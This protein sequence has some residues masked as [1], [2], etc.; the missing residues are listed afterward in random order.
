MRIFV[1]LSLTL[2]LL[3]PGALAQ[4]TPA[5]AVLRALAAHGTRWTSGQIADWVSEGKLTYF[6]VDGPQATFSVTLVR[7]GKSRVQ[8]VI[9]QTS[10]ELRQGSDGTTSWDSLGGE[11]APLAQ[12]NTQS[13][14]EAQTVRSIQRLFNYPLEGLSLRDLGATDA[15]RVIE[16]EDTSG[17][18]TS[19][20]ID[21]RTSLITRLEFVIGQSKDLFSQRP[22]PRVE[23][24]V[25][26]DFRVVQEV[27]TPFRI[28]RYRDSIKV[29]DMQF[30]SVQYNAAVK[31]EVF[32]P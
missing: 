20:F 32:K 13:F 16:A 5:Q 21:S 3:V 29:E 27:T 8:R 1:S 30:T 12:G 17:K 22:V 24:Y 4:E 2:S 7:K 15:A 26:S 10:A 6:T 31:D 9:K 14:I 25:F 11:F 19:Y 23:A 18:K 28:E